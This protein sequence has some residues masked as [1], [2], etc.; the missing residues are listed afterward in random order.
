MEVFNKIE[1]KNYNVCCQDCGHNNFELIKNLR[2]ILASCKKC[3]FAYQLRYV[4]RKVPIIAVNPK[5]SV[6]PYNIQRKFVT[7][8]V[9]QR[10]QHW[11]P[12]GVLSV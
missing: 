5:S 8:Y 11:V 1:N 12:V 6:V 3:G 9:T 4:M 7:T 2:M 10:V